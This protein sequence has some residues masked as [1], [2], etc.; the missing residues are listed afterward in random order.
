MVCTIFALAAIGAAAF[1]PL[2]HPRMA[3]NPS[4]HGVH[5]TLYGE[6]HCSLAGVLILTFI[7]LGSATLGQ[8]SEREVFSSRCSSRPARGHGEEGIATTT[9]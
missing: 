7:A 3:Q 1:R 2:I 6:R 5:R 8:G 9:V 4:E